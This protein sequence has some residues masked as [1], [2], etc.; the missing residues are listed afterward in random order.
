MCFQILGFACSFIEKLVRCSQPDSGLFVLEIM[1]FF[2]LVCQQIQ[3]ILKKKLDPT[4]NSSKL[5]ILHCT[6]QVQLMHNGN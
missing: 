1:C 3:V 6:N 5:C 2:F 4:D